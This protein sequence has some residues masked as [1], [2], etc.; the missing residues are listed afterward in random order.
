MTQFGW[1]LLLELCLVFLCLHL[2]YLE[3][4]EF[5]VRSFINSGSTNLPGIAKTQAVGVAHVW[6]DWSGWVCN[7]WN[8]KKRATKINGMN[9]LFIGFWM[10]AKSRNDLSWLRLFYPKVQLLEQRRQQLDE[11][12]Q[13]LDE[14]M[15]HEQLGL[16]RIHH[17][18]YI[19]HIRLVHDILSRFLILKL[20]IFLL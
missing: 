6:Y 8:Q 5:L 2:I 13:L 14:R 19:H 9:I 10:I 11:Q 3:S 4:S 15:R 16:H 17:I 7:T 12:R 18:H 20:K 1:I